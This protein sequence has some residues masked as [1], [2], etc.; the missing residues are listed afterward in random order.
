VPMERVSE[1]PPPFPTLCSLASS[2]KV[3]MRSARASLLLARTPCRPRV[4]ESKHISLFVR[5]SIFPPKNTN[6][7]SLRSLSHHRLLYPASIKKNKNPARPLFF[8]PPL[9]FFR[10]FGASPLYF[11]L[12]PLSSLTVFLF[13]CL[14]RGFL[15]F[16]TTPFP[17][18]LCC[19]PPCLPMPFS[20][21]APTL[22]IAN[23]ASFLNL[24]PPSMGVLALAL[25]FCFMI[26]YLNKSWIEIMITRLYLRIPACL[27]GQIRDPFHSSH[28]RVLP[29]LR[30]RYQCP[31]LSTPPLEEF[32]GGVPKG[33]ILLLIP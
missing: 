20:D 24:L 27:L 14:R 26:V 23:I 31:P 2:S 13:L 4:N 17:F 9:F 18:S 11:S 10:D 8:P 25:Y 7:I 21:N 5:A 6:L 32:V 30:F 15:T 33:F 1:G 29:F 22:E 16:V 19:Y 12:T 28:F 3:E